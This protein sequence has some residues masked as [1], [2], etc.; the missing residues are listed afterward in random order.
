MNIALII[1]AVTLLLWIIWTLAVVYGIEWPTY[2]IIEKKQGYEIREYES[3]TVAEIEVEGN[4]KQALYAW[5]RQLAGY[6]FGGNIS[7]TSIGVSASLQTM[8]APEN[9]A[10]TVPVME[11]ASGNKKHT[12]AFTMPSK[13][14][15]ETLPQPNN[16]KIVLRNVPKSRKAVIKYSWYAT[17]K[18]VNTKKK[19]LK[20]LLDRDGYIMKGEM[21]SAQY[22]PPMSF[23]FLRRNEI[24]VDV[25]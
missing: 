20:N 16:P 21:I 6:I 4:M 2:R 25:E 24:M 22:N 1:I 8:R 3:Y 13:Y 9:I 18:R 5:F 17:E 7:R 23:P 19:Q 12:I 11:S 10:M 14:T 15:L